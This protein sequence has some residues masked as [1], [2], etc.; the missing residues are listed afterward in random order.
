[1]VQ[2][3][4]RKPRTKRGANLGCS[5]RRPIS[6]P[7]N[8]RS[9]G[10]PK[11]RG[12]IQQNTSHSKRKYRSSRDVERNKDGRVSNISKS[13]HIHCKVQP[14]AFSGFTVFLVQ[15]F[16]VS[17]GRFFSLCLRGNFSPCFF[18]LACLKLKVGNGL[19]PRAGVQASHT[20]LKALARRRWQSKEPPCWQSVKKRRPASTKVCQAPACRRTKATH[21]PD[22]RPGFVKGLESLLIVLAVLLRSACC[23]A[24]SLVFEVCASFCC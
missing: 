13:A 17:A 20:R 1:M 3:R 23:F 4:G 16:D 6:T 2:L 7:E 15:L 5:T 21:I 18:F 9:L 10:E 24:H 22:R 12:D 19:W 11:R 8:K 14:P